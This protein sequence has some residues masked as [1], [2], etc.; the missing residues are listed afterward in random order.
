[1][2]KMSLIQSIILAAVGI[3]SMTDA[4]PVRA[5]SFSDNFD[6]G[7]IDSRYTAIGDTSFSESSGR[8]LIPLINPGDGV[9]ISLS[10]LGFLADCFKIKFDT[11]DFLAGQGVKIDLFADNQLNNSQTNFFS[12]SIVRDVVPD[13]SLDV[14]RHD[15]TN[16]DPMTLTSDRKKC[17]LNITVKLPSGTQS[18]IQPSFPCI[19]NWSNTFQADWTDSILFDGN[20]RWRYDGFG[21]GNEE[22]KYVLSIL[23]SEQLNFDRTINKTISR[24]NVTYVSVLPRDPLLSIESVEAEDIHPIPEPSSVLSLI[25]LGTIGAGL[26][27]K[28]KLNFSKSTEKDPEKVC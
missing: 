21:R 26:R 7:I 4:L 8:L 24:V 19:L 9:S 3:F 27:L 23:N 15:I 20:F 10:D 5:V 17:V 11:I 22:Q 6:D 13:D 18:I 14:S 12:I 28:H 1:M 16:L 25:I 2:F